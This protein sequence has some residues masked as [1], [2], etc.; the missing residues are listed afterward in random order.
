LPA[1]VAFDGRL[2][3]WGFPKKAVSRCHCGGIGKKLKVARPL[4]SLFPVNAY[5][6]IISAV[7]QAT[8]PF[9]NFEIAGTM[10]FLGLV[11][12]HFVTTRIGQTGTHAD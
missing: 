6:K 10:G 5:L 8:S 1:K 3:V 4:Q 7:W 9:L 11:L 12:Q 2:L